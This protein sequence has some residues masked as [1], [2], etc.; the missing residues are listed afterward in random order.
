MNS[1]GYTAG[2]LLATC[3]LLV[4]G[5]AL[6]LLEVQEYGGGSAVASEPA[7][8]TADPA[9][10]EPT[11]GDDDPGAEEGEGGP[12]AGEPEED[13]GGDEAEGAD[14]DTALEFE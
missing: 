5:L 10:P 13:A 12:P 14:E 6:T 11:A 2:L 4:F 7:P 3:V 9:P 8:R 1:S